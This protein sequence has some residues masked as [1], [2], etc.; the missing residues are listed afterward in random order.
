MSAVEIV[1]HGVVR[2]VPY[3]VAVGLV[4]RGRAQWNDPAPKAPKKAK[5][6]ISEGLEDQKRASAPPKQPKAKKKSIVSSPAK[7]VEADQTGYEP[8][9]PDL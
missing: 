9:P 7:S 4:S 6:G 8:S 3:R 5:D 2:T 1:E